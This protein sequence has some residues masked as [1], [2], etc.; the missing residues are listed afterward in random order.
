VETHCSANRVRLLAPESSISCNS[1]SSHI[2]NSRTLDTGIIMSASNLPNSVLNQGLSSV[3]PGTTSMI[4]S[5]QGPHQ[6]QQNYLVSE[7]GLRREEHAHRRRRARE[8]SITREAS[9][10]QESQYCQSRVRG[11]ASSRAEAYATRSS[12]SGTSNWLG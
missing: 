9:R 12:S 6:I 7:M 1:H 10:I 3:P 2:M 5:P 11:R 8:S 4:C